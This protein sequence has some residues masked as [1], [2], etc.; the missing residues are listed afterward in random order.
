[1]STAYSI[2]E[3]LQ[4]ALKLAQVAEEISLD[5]FRSLD[6]VVETK[7][8]RSPVTDADRLVEKT[9]REMIASERPEDSVFAEEFQDASVTLTETGRQW[10]MDPIDGTA[11]FLRGNPIWGNLIALAIDGKPVIGVANLP[12]LH[13]RYWAGKSLG[14]FTQDLHEPD[15]IPRQIHVSQVASLADAAFNLTRLNGWVEAGYGQKALEVSTAVWRN[16]GASDLWTYC[17]VAEGIADAV[18]EFDLAPYDIAALVPI[19]E[20]AG[21]KFTD[22]AGNPAFSGNDYVVSNGSIHQELLTL[23]TQN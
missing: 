16:F 4:F 6:L 12:A 22:F 14:A 18:V 21:G 8:D 23:L 5:R 15:S 11:N 7:P 9:L 17:M 3:D 13:K 10:I 2:K 19:V 20:E 1:M